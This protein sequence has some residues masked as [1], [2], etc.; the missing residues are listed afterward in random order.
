VVADP[1]PITRAQIA[2][3]V[4]NDP[5]AIRAI[6]RLFKVAGELT[7]SDIAAI[8]S[9]IEANSLAI[10]VNA[11]SAEVTAAILAT[12]AQQVMQAD[13]ATAMAQQALDALVSARQALDLLATAP[14]RE[15]DGLRQTVDLL[16]LAP[17]ATPPKREVYGTFYDLNTQ[18]AAVINTAY[19]VSLSNTDLSF[20]VFLA[21]SP[22]TRI[23]VDQGGLFNFQ[24]SIQVD[25]TTGGKGL[26]YLWYAKNGSDVANSATRMRLDGNNSESV[27]AW[28][29]IF[30]LKAGDYI[31]YK[32]SVN[33]TG[34]EIKSFATAAPAP[35][36][37]SVIVTVTN[38]IG[39]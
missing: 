39:G 36:T 31:E 1:K 9:A 2:A 17:P 18:Q 16:A 32:W 19:T 33:D 15:I 23:T 26:F 30:A 24:H 13:T 10:G 8:N 20:G 6:E 37:P 29:Y 35:A 22:A 38:N 21:G 25:K 27:A 4:G 5:E 14:T 11:N 7:P 3:F 34:V 28:N 12:L